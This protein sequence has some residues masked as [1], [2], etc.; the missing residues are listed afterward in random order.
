MEAVEAPGIGNKVWALFLEDLP[1]GLS[2]SSGC[3][4]VLAEAMHLSSSQAFSSS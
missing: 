2:V 1:D 4:L 3:L